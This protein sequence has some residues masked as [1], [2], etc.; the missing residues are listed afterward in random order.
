[1]P[2]IM[3]SKICT[4]CN[5]DKPLG[6]FNKRT[7]SRDGLR[8]SCKKCVNNMS[9][10]YYKTVLGLITRMYSNQKLHSKYRN[11]PMPEYSKKEFKEWVINNISFNVLYKNWVESDYDV[12]LVPSVDRL[13]DN[14][15]YKFNNIQI[16]TWKDNRNKG[17]ETKPLNLKSIKSYLV[18]VAK[19]GKQDELLKDICKSILNNLK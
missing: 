14:I 10:T 3:K 2:K 6:E 11:H 13:D 15:H 8:F 4:K 9:N 5:I 19:S 7:A 16:V 12:E 18:F 1:M 17:F